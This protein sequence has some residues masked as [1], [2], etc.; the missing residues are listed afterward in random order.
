M[1][2][3]LIKS[4]LDYVEETE[5][6]YVYHRWCMISTIA[7]LL[8]RRFY[9]PFAGS[10]INANLYTQMIGNV[11]TRKSTAIKSA[12]R[13]MKSA[14]YLKFAGRKVT[15]ERFLL[16]MSGQLDQAAQDG[17][18]DLKTESNKLLEMQ[19]FGD[20]IDRE[21]KE[22][23]IAADE[24]N[25]FS[26]GD[27][28]EFFELLGD[29]WDWDDEVLPYTYRIKNS[30][31]NIWQPTVNILSGNTPESFSRAFPP[32]II[33]QGFMSRMLIIYGEPSSRKYALP[34]A[35][36]QEWTDAI[37]AALKNI[38]TS[39]LGSAYIHPKY[40][41][42]GG[43]LDLIYRQWQPLEDH[44]FRNYGTRR[45]TQLLKLCM[46]LAASKFTNEITEDII[47]EANTILSA[48]E[49]NMSKAIGEYGKNKDSDISNLTLTVIR[50]SDKP[51]RF[52]ELFKKFRKD[53][54][55]QGQLMTIINNL[56][57]NELIQYIP[58]HKGWLIHKEKVREVDFVDWNYLTQEER[59]LL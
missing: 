6:P 40:W 58:L 23:M 3:D 1:P 37:V 20:N 53:V 46:I 27:K 32:E 48:V 13:L 7:T 5:P 36:N 51:V 45:Y 38:H 29:L 16:D 17:T 21:V 33:G 42:V 26:V 55:G 49:Q 41:E 10:V 2:A 54:S 9:I 43:L 25:V 50:D 30:E 8:G 59:D 14:G 15:K 35:P 4:Y 28:M 12:T 11:G 56:V 22:V 47:I 44:R 34:K 39:D 31:I 24:F 19:L 52:P 57:Q 18:I